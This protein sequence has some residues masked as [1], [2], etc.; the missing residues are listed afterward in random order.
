MATPSTHK[1]PYGLVER[2]CLIC[3]GTHPATLT[4]CYGETKGYPTM[5][6]F[7]AAFKDGSLKLPLYFDPHLFPSI[8]FFNV[9]LFSLCLLSYERIVEAMKWSDKLVASLI[10]IYISLFFAYRG[11]SRVRVPYTTLHAAVCSLRNTCRGRI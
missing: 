2:F 9:K 1:G 6:Q 8:P 3:G 11:R 4:W 10:Y 7:R 5:A